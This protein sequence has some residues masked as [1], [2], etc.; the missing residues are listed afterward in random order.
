MTIDQ[1]AL[2]ELLGRFV[3][4]LGAGFHLLSAVVGD[5][6]GLY[7]GLAECGPATSA[8]LAA[9]TTVSERYVREWLRGQAAG[10]YV[11]YD[12]AADR[13]LLTD[14]QAFALAAPDGMSLPSAF[15]LPLAVLKSADR[16]TEAARTGAGFGWHEHDQALFEGT[17]RFF[18][19]GYVANLVTAWIP[20]LDGVAEKLRRGAKVADVGCGHG[21]STLLLARSFP[22]S[23]VTGFDYHGPSVDQARKRAAEEG[24][25]GQVSFEA[26]SAATFP[27]TGYD[28]VAIFDALHDMGDPVGAARHIRESLAPDGTFLLVEPNAA[29]RVEDNL[30]PVGR[31]FYSAS[32]FVC[33]PHSLSEDVGLALGAQAGEARLRDV[34]TEA[35]FSRVRRATETPFNMVLEARP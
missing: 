10:G 16:L 4:D 5:R 23:D 15:Q 35:G 9:H 26:A 17:E 1:K 34:L 13:Y 33:V 12:P 21:A 14:E 8:E 24:L 29:D 25:A 3:T 11:T 2:D 7:R 28:L 19:P 27:G 32:T 18:R 20:A 30:N 31:L 22:A 6:L